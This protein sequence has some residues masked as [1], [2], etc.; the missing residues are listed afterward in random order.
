[1]GRYHNIEKIKNALNTIKKI[2]PDIILHTHIICGFPT[3]TEEEFKETLKFLNDAD[4]DSCFFYAFSCKHGTSA[5]KMQQNS[6]E[7][8]EKRT[9]YAKKFIKKSGYTVINMEKTRFYA[10]KRR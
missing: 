6:V 5:E 2:D 9:K 3:E 8:I 7:E 1:M 4:I 10:Y